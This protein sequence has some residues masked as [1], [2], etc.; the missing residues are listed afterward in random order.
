[1]W[2]LPINTSQCQVLHAVKFCMQDL[3]IISIITCLVASHCFD[4]I[5]LLIV[6][7]PLI[8]T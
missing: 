8:A 2:Q 7:L 3:Q 5:L 4:V 1:M 6:V